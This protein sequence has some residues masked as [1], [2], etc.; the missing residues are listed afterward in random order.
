MEVQRL[1]LRGPG[2]EQRKDSPPSAHT[3][4]LNRVL[5]FAMKSL[6]CPQMKKV[7][8]TGLLYSHVIGNV[9][10]KG[11]LCEALLHNFMIEK[12]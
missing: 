1:I 4:S 10:K 11:K 3:D 7:E 6:S 9:R 8:I 5:T 12:Q 2:K